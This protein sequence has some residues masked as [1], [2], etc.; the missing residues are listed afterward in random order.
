MNQIQRKFETT[1][2]NSTSEMLEVL[3]N[4]AVKT[5]TVK[6]Y[7]VETDPS[8]SCLLISST[9]TEDLIG[10]LDEAKNHKSAMRDIVVVGSGATEANTQKLLQY[11][12]ELNNNITDDQRKI[13]LANF[14]DYDGNTASTKSGFERVLI[15]QRQIDEA[16]CKPF[17]HTSKDFDPTR[18]YPRR[19]KG[20][21]KRY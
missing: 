20:K 12:E 8:G 1:F 9:T 18:L 3:R 15:M 6:T 2:F 5:D 13:I 7:V 4:E 17:S 14:G 19:G 11:A 21:I 10:Y 16:F